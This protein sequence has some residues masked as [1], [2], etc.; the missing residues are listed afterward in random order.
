M[1]IKPPPLTLPSPVKPATS[2]S[3]SANPSLNYSAPANWQ[4]SQRVQAVIIKITENQILLDIQGI[5]THSEKPDIPGLQA[6]DILKLQ[7]EQLKPQ[8]Q[9]KIISLQKMA[10]INTF[11]QNMKN[12]PPPESTA[13]TSLLKNISYIANRPALRPSPLAVEVN[14]AVRT[15]FKNI[16]A[17]YNLKTAAQ[18]KTQLL[19][20]GIFIE[21]KIKNQL[22]EAIN[23]YL[24]NMS[25]IFETKLDASINSILDN[26][27]SAQL[28]R[29]AN[30]I[31]TQ[32]LPPSDVAKSDNLA[33]SSNKHES[34]PNTTAT[35]QQSQK[36]IS[37]QASLQ[38]IT[39]REEAMQTF[40]RQI[41]SSQNHIQQTQ[42]HNLND[43]HAGRPAWLIELPIKDGQDIDLFKFQID[44]EETKHGQGEYKKVWSVVLQFNLSGLGEVKTHI[45]MHNDLISAQF[46]SEN[47]NTLALFRNNVDFL[48][49]RLNYNGLNV[50]NIECA[51]R[52]ISQEITV[53]SYS[54][55]LDSLDKRS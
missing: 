2:V 18:L 33:N 42:L 51:Q 31:K 4:V 24:P 16:P 41:E 53:R 50:G 32:T 17:P 40:L 6:G 23:N 49:K 13:Y 22:L 37:D 52:K 45:K 54:A 26:D 3:T 9:F 5:K 7:I 29:L 46:F 35:S 21:N 10:N 48:R 1:E 27:L 28:H 55:D 15:I 44:E 11:T 34:Q 36:F 12:S 47:T 20:S 14:A 8:A 19:N 25:A 38:N 39:Q 30:I 43:T